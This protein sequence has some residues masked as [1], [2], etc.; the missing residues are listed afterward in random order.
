VEE[1]ILDQSNL[2]LDPKLSPVKVVAIEDVN[3]DGDGNI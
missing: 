2:P 3:D 1:S